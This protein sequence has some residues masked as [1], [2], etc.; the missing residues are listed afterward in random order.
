[1]RIATGASSGSAQMTGLPLRVPVAE[2]DLLA[3]TLSP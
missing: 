3:S 1:M 2:T